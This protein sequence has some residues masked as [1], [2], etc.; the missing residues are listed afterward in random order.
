M[1][2]SYSLTITK[3]EYY[4]ILQCYTDRTLTLICFLL[5]SLVEAKIDAEGCCTVCAVICNLGGWVPH[6]L[7]L[8]ALL[9]SVLKNSTVAAL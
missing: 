6:E 7:L 9:G 2:L 1:T 3:R 5:Q 8:L 4:I